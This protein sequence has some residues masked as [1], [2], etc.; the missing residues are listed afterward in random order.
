MTTLYSKMH[1]GMSMDRYD[2]LYTFYFQYEWSI[3]TKNNDRT[4]DAEYS[5]L[6]LPTLSLIKGLKFNN[7]NTFESYIDLW[8]R[9]EESQNRH[10]RHYQRQPIEEKE[11]YKWIETIEESHKNLVNARQI[12]IVADREADIYDLFGRYSNTDIKLIIRYKCNG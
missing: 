3:D 12:N 1:N 7:D 8:H 10:E 11:S 6:T 9:K 2:L 4:F 5:S